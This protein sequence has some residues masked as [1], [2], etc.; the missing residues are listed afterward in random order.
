MHSSVVF[1]FSVWVWGGDSGEANAHRMTAR[2]S[3]WPVDQQTHGCEYP[4]SVQ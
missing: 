4:Q 3:I 2:L 1:V